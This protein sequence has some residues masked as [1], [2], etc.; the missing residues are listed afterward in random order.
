ML[1]GMLAAHEECG[2]EVIDVNGVPHRR[3]YGMS[4]RQAMTKHA[5]GVAIYRAG[6]GKEV[7]LP[8]RGPVARLLQDILGGLHVLHVHMLVHID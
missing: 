2:G 6:E 5:G 8:D 3:F 7:L 4:S 1:G